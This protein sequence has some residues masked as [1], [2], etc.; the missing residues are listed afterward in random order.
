MS[1]LPLKTR[2]ERA[3]AYWRPILGLESWNIQIRYDERECLGTCVARP[4]YLEAEL[5]FNTRR[6]GS[7]IKTKKGL[8]ELVLHELVHCVIWHASERAV[9]QVTHAILRARD[10]GRGAL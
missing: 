4:S 1:G 3:A 6:I 8:E 2:I 7:E 5:T 10:A 9:S